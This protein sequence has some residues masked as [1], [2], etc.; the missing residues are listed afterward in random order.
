[1]LGP[2]APAPRER[3]DALHALKMELGQH[4]AFAP[5]KQAFELGVVMS[6]TRIANGD[7]R[8]T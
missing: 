4:L 7:C 5:A 8:R 2:K 1:M 3:Q 6:L